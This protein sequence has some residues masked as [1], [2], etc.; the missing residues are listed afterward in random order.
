VKWRSIFWA[1]IVRGRSSGYLYQAITT[2]NIIDNQ[3]RRLVVEGLGD[4]AAYQKT[5]RRENSAYFQIQDR[6]TEALREFEPKED[7]L[8][9]LIFVGH[10][11]GCNIISSNA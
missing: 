2:T 1:D 9:P 10:S 5:W 7:P 4:A 11:L 6:I 3:Y 8:P